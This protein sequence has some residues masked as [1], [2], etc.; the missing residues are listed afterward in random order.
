MGVGLVFVKTSRAESYAEFVWEGRPVNEMS[1]SDPERFVVAQKPQSTVSPGGVVGKQPWLLQ[2]QIPLYLT[3]GG[4]LLLTSIGLIGSLAEEQASSNTTTSTIKPVLAPS[5]WGVLF[6]SGLSVMSSSVSAALWRAYPQ[7]WV[8]VLGSVLAGGIALSG[9]LFV[10]LGQDTLMLSL[11]WGFLASLPI[12]IILNV[13]GWINIRHHQ[14]VKALEDRRE[15]ES[16][17]SSAIQ[18]QVVPAILPGGTG[19]Q[20]V[21]QF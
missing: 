6:F 2:T 3:G 13:V 1:V 14:Q 9:G 18:I 11:G 7:P 10:A 12:H 15:K 8:G 16:Q 21:G 20:V 19:I 4:G 17:R 5:P